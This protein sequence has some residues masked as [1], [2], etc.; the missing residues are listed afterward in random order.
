MFQ[1]KTSPTN[2]GSRTT[3]QM[4]ELKTSPTNAG[5]KRPHR[6]SSKNLTKGNQRRVPNDLTDIRAKNLTNQS[7]V[8]NDLTDVQA[9]TSPTNAGPKRPHRCSS[10]KPHQP[11]QVP[12]D[13]TDV[14][15]KASPKATNAGSRTP[16]RP[17][18]C[19]DDLVEI[20]KTWRNDQIGI[21]CTRCQE[22]QYTDQ[23]ISKTNCL[24]CSR[25]AELDIQNYAP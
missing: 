13:L 14:R 16:E 4:F 6:F 10:Q 9:K 20:F 11:T 18:R 15:T 3:S 19:L 17:F 12:N 8:P 5:P 24:Y 7:G 22:I 23:N 2:A 21:R 1:P 25:P